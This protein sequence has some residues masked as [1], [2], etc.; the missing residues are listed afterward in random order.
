MVARG[1]LKSDGTCIVYF[2]DIFDIIQFI[3]AVYAESGK[4]S[5]VRDSYTLTRSTERDWDYFNSAQPYLILVQF[6]SPAW[7]PNRGSLP[8]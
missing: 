3:G 8:G 6:V 4:V 5:Y 1:G 2:I 7:C